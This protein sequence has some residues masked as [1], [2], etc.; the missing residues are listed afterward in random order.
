M[1]EKQSITQQPSAVL[2]PEINLD[3]WFA[4][5]TTLLVKEAKTHPSTSNLSFL[6]FIIKNHHSFRSQIR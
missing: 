2:P 1:V 4:K 3:S 5:Q 6:A